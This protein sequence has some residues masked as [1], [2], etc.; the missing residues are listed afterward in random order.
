MTRRVGPS[1]QGQLQG[2]NG[3]L[4][5][6][7]NMIAPLLFTQIFAFAVGRYRASNMP[8]APFLLASC[9]LA[10]ALIMGWRVTGRREMQR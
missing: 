1:E 4:N 3:S 9:F 8:G 7:A 10:A 2:A 6:I 5:G